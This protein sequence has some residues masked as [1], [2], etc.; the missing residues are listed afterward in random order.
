MTNLVWIHTC[1][2]VWRSCAQTPCVGSFN[3]YS[4]VSL[5]SISDSHIN[6]C[7]NAT[8]FTCSC[9]IHQTKHGDMSGLY[10][11]KS[12]G[13]AV[14]YDT[15]DFS[16][17]LP[18]KNAQMESPQG[19]SLIAHCMM[20]PALF[21]LLWLAW[22]SLFWAL[23]QQLKHFLQSFCFTCHRI[24]KW[25]EARLASMGNNSRFTGTGNWK[26]PLKGSSDSYTNLNLIHP[27]TTRQGLN[28]IFL[29]PNFF[30]PVILELLWLRQCGS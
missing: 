29:P 9:K 14:A 7:C 22:R 5:L 30:R 28:L 3:A 6:R 2:Y 27:P 20:L 10:V 13:S 19:I 23:H 4:L 21:K 15:E 12:L 11:I 1:P 17:L 18:R 8:C 24:S 26:L 25:F 16:N